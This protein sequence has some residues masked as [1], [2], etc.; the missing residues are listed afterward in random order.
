MGKVIIGVKTK[1]PNEKDFIE[2]TTIGRMEK[3]EDKIIV[4]YDESELTG[5][6]NTIT[7]V[8]I[9]EK[10][11]ILERKG[12]YESK[13]EF[14]NNNE[15]VSLYNTP[16]GTLSITINTKRLSIEKYDDTI[17]VSASYITTIE[18]ERQGLTRME[19]KINMK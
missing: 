2:L 5:L 11:V 12:D 14:E 17:F 19:L 4:R 3:Y 10:K 9:M 6:D 18:G 7:S 15:N 16:Y 13:I 1:L 8:I